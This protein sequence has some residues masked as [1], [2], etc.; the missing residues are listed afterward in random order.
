M[1]NIPHLCAGL[2]HDVRSSLPLGFGAWDNGYGVGPQSPHLSN[3][4]ICQ[5]WIPGLLLCELQYERERRDHLSARFYGEY[6]VVVVRLFP[7]L[8]H[9]IRHRR[10]ENS[11]T[12]VLSVRYQRQ[13]TD[14]VFAF[15]FVFS[16]RLLSG[17]KHR[18]LFLPRNAQSTNTKLPQERN[19][20]S[21]N[22]SLIHQSGWVGVS[23][24]FKTWCVM[25]CYYP[26]WTACA[27]TD[28][29]HKTC[30][31]HWLFAHLPGFR[32]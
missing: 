24:Q 19:G 3:D 16:F 11:G 13:T 25:L 29:R 17:T 15:A 28:Y 21:S 32:N 9:R 4:F 6:V 2:S 22:L 10:R 31:H 20:T 5:A 30:R 14:Q 1:P 23:G 7:R 8:G 27:D 12:T 26:L 18:N